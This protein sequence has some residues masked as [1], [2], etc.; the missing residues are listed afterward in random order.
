MIGN[1]FGQNKYELDEF[2]DLKLESLDSHKKNSNNQNNSNQRLILYDD[3]LYLL[4]DDFDFGEEEL[5]LQN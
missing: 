2:D 5:E 4:D 3:N 1:S